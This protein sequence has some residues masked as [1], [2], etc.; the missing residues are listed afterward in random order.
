LIEIARAIG[1]ARERIEWGE[2]IVHERTPHDHEEILEA[3]RKRNGKL[4][5]DRTKA[6]LL[7]ARR[8]LLGGAD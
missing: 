1:R 2:L 8:S 6:H 7:H 5:Y 3:L 4:A